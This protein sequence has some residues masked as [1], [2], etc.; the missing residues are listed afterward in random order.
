[1]K[2]R[3]SL[4]GSRL[5]PP[6]FNSLKARAPTQNS[7]CRSPTYRG[8]T[9]LYTPATLMLQ[10]QQVRHSGPHMNH[11]AAMR[12]KSSK[13]S[14]SLI[15]KVS[16]ASVPPH[17]TWRMKNYAMPT[18]K[19]SQLYTKMEQLMKSW[20]I[21]KVSLLRKTGYKLAQKQLQIYVKVEV[22]VNNHALVQL[23][24]SKDWTFL[25]SLK[26]GVQI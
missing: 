23:F 9:Q 19:H 22:Q 12:W 11:S 4:A 1:T 5:A 14:N 2:P 25:F 7:S 10:Q 3:M 24:L 6:R 16:R 8:R 26:A 13:T 17:S 20:I 15:S 21:P 18:M